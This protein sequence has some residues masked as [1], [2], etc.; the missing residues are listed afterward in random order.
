[1]TSSELHSGYEQQSRPQP[2]IALE[3]GPQFRRNLG[4]AQRLAGAG[5]RRHRQ[6]ARRRL[7]LTVERPPPGRPHGA[8][9]VRPPVRRRARDGRELLEAL[10]RTID[11]SDTIIVASDVMMGSPGGRPGRTR[12]ILEAP[13]YKVVVYGNH[14]QDG[15]AGV[16]TD[17]FD[18]AQFALRIAADGVLAVTHA[19][20]TEVPGSVVN[21]HGHTHQHQA[22]SADRHISV[23]QESVFVWLLRI[24]LEGS[25]SDPLDH[26]PR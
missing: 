24:E 23:K 6:A 5:N 18:E 22:A 10:H 19:P 14:D 21:V 12:G 8:R 3:A 7:D 4:D 2:P 25:V 9:L 15:R 26:S 16:V 1:M 11:A 17:G 13:G 20:H